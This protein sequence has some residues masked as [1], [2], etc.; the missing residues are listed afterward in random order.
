MIP[1]VRVSEESFN[2]KGGMAAGRRGEEGGEAVFQLGENQLNVTCVM[3]EMP[4]LASI[5]L[6]SIAFIVDTNICKPVRGESDSS[7]M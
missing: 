7:A 6:G 5:V 2:G 1:C 3:N 4:Y